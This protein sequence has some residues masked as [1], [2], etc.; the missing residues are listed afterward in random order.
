M[1]TNALFPAPTWTS[2]TMYTP[3][4]ASSSAVEAADQG[5]TATQTKRDSKTTWTTWTVYPSEYGDASRLASERICHD[6]VARRHRQLLHQSAG[7]AAQHHRVK[8]HD[9]WRKKRVMGG[10]GEW[11]LRPGRDGILFWIC[12]VV[13][14]GES[15][16]RRHL[17]FRSLSA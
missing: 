16:Q 4:S 1:M 9:P 2:P 12:G 13:F 15:H 5:A 11:T 17:K 8:L 3:I 6:T 14:D 10:M 7:A